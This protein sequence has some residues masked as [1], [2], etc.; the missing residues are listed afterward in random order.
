MDDNF[1]E[2]ELIQ[3][4]L[5][6]LDASEEVDEHQNIEDLIQELN[7]S[8]LESQEVTDI[9]AELQVV[10]YLIRK[11]ILGKSWLKSCRRQLF[12][13]TTYFLTSR[14][15]TIQHP[16]KKRNL[17]FYRNQ[18]MQKLVIHQKSSGPRP[19]PR[20]FLLMKDIAYQ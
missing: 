16:K 1:S 2:D 10:L 7:E 12:S 9:P 8:N 19:I 11:Q 15:N 17:L 18:Y 3:Q 14:F 6:Q 5:S 20:S 13:K 4:Q